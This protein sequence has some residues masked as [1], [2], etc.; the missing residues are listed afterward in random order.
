MSLKRG[1]ERREEQSGRNLLLENW[2]FM[3]SLIAHKREA[4][5]SNFPLRMWCKM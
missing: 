3:V 4:S 1:G 2:T 5:I